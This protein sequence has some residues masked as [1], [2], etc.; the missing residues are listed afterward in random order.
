MEVPGSAGG[1]VLAFTMTILAMRE[2]HPELPLPQSCLPFK[3]GEIYAEDVR[4]II[5]PIQDLKRTI[6][7]LLMS[8][9]PALIRTEVVYDVPVHEFVTEA[10]RVNEGRLGGENVDADKI[11]VAIATPVLAG[12]GKLRLPFIFSIAISMICACVDELVIYVG[13]ELG[14]PGL[15][16]PLS[17]ERESALRD[18]TSTEVPSRRQQIC[19]TRRRAYHQRSPSESSSGSSRR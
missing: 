15:R 11:A 9:F 12:Q 14:F 10:F 8:T 16:E 1:S 2:M 4:A 7:L 17:K 3:N 13:R 5:D 6:D 19:R 18:A